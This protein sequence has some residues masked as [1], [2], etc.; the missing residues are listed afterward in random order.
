MSKVKKYVKLDQNPNSIFRAS[1]NIVNQYKKKL[2]TTEIE[3]IN[4]G[5]QSKQG[6]D[7]VK[8]L[9]DYLALIKSITTNIETVDIY[10]N[11][12]EIEPNLLEG[13]GLKGGMPTKKTGTDIKEK[14]KKTKAKEDLI[15]IKKKMEEGKS[16]LK[17]D[18]KR[19]E[20]INKDY[21]AFYKQYETKSS[22]QLNEMWYNV[23]ATEELEPEEY[24]TE[25]EEEI[26]YETKTKEILG[27]FPKDESEIEERERK[28]MMDEDDLLEGERYQDNPLSVYLHGGD[29]NEESEGEEEEEKEIE[30]Q[31]IEDTLTPKP[32]NDENELQE[33]KPP[34]ITNYIQPNGTVVRKVIKE[35]FVV[36]LFTQLINQVYNAT[37]F[38]ENNISPNLTLIPKIKM[39]S[40]IKSKVFSNFEKALY[41]F[42]SNIFK[43]HFEDVKP[44]KGQPKIYPEYKYLDKTYKGLIS[45]LDELFNLMNSDIKRYS[46]GINIS[47]GYLNLK[48]AYNQM[49][50]HS[51][52]KYLM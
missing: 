3:P 15:D 31:E 47:G 2:D 18:E 26:P 30:E 42:E 34:E 40:F 43:A 12:T 16:L 32:I 37:N 44:E 19:L 35:N 24:E 5:I 39:D 41:Y 23:K 27:L 28:A 50:F 10:L 4:Q 21:P 14:D 33:K 36:S 51:P 20:K 9:S 22:N 7:V 6:Q 11:S 45:A 25:E 48:P 29:P 1:K 52:T 49:L 8:S 17:K 38:W 13:A 46:S